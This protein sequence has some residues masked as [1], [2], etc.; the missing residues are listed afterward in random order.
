MKNENQLSTTGKLKS[1]Y[2]LLLV[3]VLIAAVANIFVRV[4]Y[5]VDDYTY[6]Q[7]AVCSPSLIV[8]FMK[9][10]YLNYNGRTLAHV[11]TII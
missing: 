5:S 8:D 11:L 6:M 3:L 7:A 1:N 2:H 4:G 10:H 9:W